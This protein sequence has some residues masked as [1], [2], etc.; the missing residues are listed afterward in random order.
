M[1]RDEI[2][3][4][5]ERLK[6][7]Y[8]PYSNFCVASMVKTKEGKKYFG[9][10]IENDGIQSICSE[11][12]AFANAIS[13]G[14]REFDYMVIAAKE[15]GKS[16]LSNALPCGYCRQFISEFVDEEF[17]IFVVETNYIKEYSIKE[18]LPYS[19]KLKK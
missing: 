9:V 4:V 17:R 3:E 6:N 7:S 16:I 19:F 18:L 14:E 8:S 15:Q 12:T 2:E 11:R 13:E 10:N 1:I 5:K